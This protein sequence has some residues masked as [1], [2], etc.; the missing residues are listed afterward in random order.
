MKDLIQRLEKFESDWNQLKNLQ[1][2]V[3]LS[4]FGNQ[5]GRKRNRN[6]GQANGHK[7]NG[8]KSNGPKSTNYMDYD[9]DGFGGSPV[10]IGDDIQITEI[11]SCESSPPTK[12]MKKENPIEIEVKVSD[13]GYATSPHTRPIQ[14]IPTGSSRRKGASQVNTGTM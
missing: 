5:A 8:P 14:I 2:D 6:K 9:L 7:S 3:L 10:Q 11:T 12:I 1:P 13:P 4:L